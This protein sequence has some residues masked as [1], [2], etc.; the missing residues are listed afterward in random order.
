[1]ITSCARCGCPCPQLLDL[2]CGLDPEPS[3]YVVE[4][5]D[6][7]LS[8]NSSNTQK[9]A[10][11]NWNHLQTTTQKDPQARMKWEDAKEAYRRAEASVDWRD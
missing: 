10:V 9:M 8:A 5:P 1:M 2:F 3:A 11:D 6:C 7:G 4:C